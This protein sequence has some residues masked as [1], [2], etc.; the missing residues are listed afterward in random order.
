MFKRLNILVTLCVLIFSLTFTA[1]ASRAQQALPALPSQAAI[2]NVLAGPNPVYVSTGVPEKVDKVF[3]SAFGKYKPWNDVSKNLDYSHAASYFSLSSTVLRTLIPMQGASQMALQPNTQTSDGQPAQ[4]IG[5]QYD[6]SNGATLVVLVNGST[7]R[8]YTDGTTYTTPFAYVAHSLPSVTPGDA[9]VL[10]ASDEA[11]FEIGANLA[12]FNPNGTGIDPAA[13]TSAQ[14]ANAKLAS[15]YSYAAAFNYSA[16]VPDRVGANAR[17]QCTGA[18][19]CQPNVVYVASG[20]SG[21]GQL[22]GLMNV[23]AANDLQAYDQ[24]GKF[25]GQL[26]ADSYLVIQVTPGGPGVKGAL[27]LVGASGTNYMIPAIG[28]NGFGNGS[29]KAGIK[30]ASMCGWAW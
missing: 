21:N 10:I 9:G 27:F 22:I 30:D 24:N 29:N 17:A 23:L 18:D 28:F 16:A 19:N 8:F 15:V 11:C 7:L 13:G 5:G 3:K 12:C 14:Q 20:S 25:I 26:A 1:T 2:N 4:I 6:V